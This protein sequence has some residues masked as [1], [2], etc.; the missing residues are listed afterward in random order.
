MLHST[1]GVAT[2]T[3]PN[4]DY[5]NVFNE[6]VTLT[7]TSTPFGYQLIDDSILEGTETFQ[8]SLTANAAGGPVTVS[9]P[10]SGGVA[11]VS[12]IEDDRK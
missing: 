5:V 1:A 6:A 8:F 3:S 2:A 12:I 4:G 11:T 9:P 10:G 7:T